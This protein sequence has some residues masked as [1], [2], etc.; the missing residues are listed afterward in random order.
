MHLG[1][2]V[3]STRLHDPIVDLDAL[4]PVDCILLS[5]YHE[6]HFDAVV[7][8][9]LRREV[10]ILT[11]EHAEGCLS[12]KGE[13]DGGKGFTNVVGLGFWEGVVM[14]VKTGEEGGKRPAVKVTGMPGKHVPPGSLAVANELLGAVPP[15]NGWMVELGYLKDGEGDRME[16]GYRVYI[17]G[18]IDMLLWTS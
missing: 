6:D 13:G 2:G 5:H 14:P 9:R 18:D 16:T 3:T 15:T 17:S 10:L 1:P 12:G 11:S 8:G 7:E 4:P